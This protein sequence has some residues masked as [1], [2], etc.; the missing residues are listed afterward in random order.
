MR[1]AD[2]RS[3][4]IRSRGRAPAAPRPRAHGVRGRRPCRRPHA[5]G[6]RRHGAGGGSRS[7]PAS[8][9]STIAT[10]RLFERLL[11]RLGVASQP[12]SMSFSVSDER[13]P[14]RVRQHL[15]GGPVRH[16]GQLREPGLPAHGG[17]GAALPARGAGAA[18]GGLVDISLVDWL[19]RERFSEYFVR[20]SDRA[21][22]GGRMVGGPSRRCGASRPA[23][24]PSSSTTTACWRCASAPLA[25]HPRRLGALRRGADARRSPT[26]SARARRSSAITRAAD[27]VMVHAARRRARALRRGGAG[28]P[29]RSGAGAADRRHRGR[30]RGARRNPLRRERGR[31][32]HRCA[33]AA[34]A[35]ARR[36]RAG[37]TTCSTSRARWRR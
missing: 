32:A 23:S 27:H 13:A 30:A 1:I 3:G 2:R 26:A 19:R 16:A 29:L 5:Y 14:L 20:A 11:Q 34:P 22:G 37:T 15:A 8:S 9:S 28:H 12:S 4:H 33:A 35:P 25:G 24:W 7:T 10:T 6:R 36:G 17:R 31:P 18:A 21:P